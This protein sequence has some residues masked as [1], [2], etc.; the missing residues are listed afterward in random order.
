M[1][2]STLWV[3]LNSGRVGVVTGPYKK[4]RNYVI[5]SEAAVG[6][7]VEES[8]FPAA[9]GGAVLCTAGCGSFNS[10]AARSG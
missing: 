9:E 8:V 5:L 1:T 10:P 2:T 4:T 7:V 6:C 3:L